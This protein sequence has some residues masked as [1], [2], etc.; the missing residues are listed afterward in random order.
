MLGSFTGRRRFSTARR[1][2]ALGA[3]HPPENLGRAALI[4]ESFD[5]QLSGLLPICE[6]A[7]DPLVPNAVLSVHRS[8]PFSV[9]FPR[10]SRAGGRAEIGAP[11]C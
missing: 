3:R 8:G 2:M 10:Y 7:N 1:E 9:R 5:G 11:I 4:M 6:F